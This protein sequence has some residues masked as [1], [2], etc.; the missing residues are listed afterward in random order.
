MRCEAQGC[1]P[2]SPL[3]SS[4]ISVYELSSFVLLLPNINISNSACNF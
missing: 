4:Y 2:S 1:S 3:T